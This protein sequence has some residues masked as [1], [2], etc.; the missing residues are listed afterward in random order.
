ME[1]KREKNY[2]NCYNLKG[3]TTFFVV[4]ILRKRHTM[5]A[6]IDIK[7]KNKRTMYALKYF[8]IYK[9]RDITECIFL[10]RLTFLSLP[11]IL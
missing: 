7:N 1:L 5:Y 3:K 6:F 8:L 10:K 4:K 9:A 11:A 2:G